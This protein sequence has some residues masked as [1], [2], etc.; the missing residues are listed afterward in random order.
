MER[1]SREARHARLVEL[2]EAMDDELYEWR[3]QHPDASLDEIVTQVTPRRRRLM[4]EWVKQLA[5]QEGHGVVVEGLSCPHCGQPLVYK[6]DPPRTLEHL[7]G[8]TELRRAYYHCP[9][10]RTGFFPPR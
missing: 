3:A 1:Q 5:C 10:C 9:A 8:E 2:V 7:E 4:G 6:G